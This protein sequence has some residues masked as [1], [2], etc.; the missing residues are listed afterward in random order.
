MDDVRR[1]RP[2]HYRSIFISDVHLGFKGCQ[3]DLL[4]DFLRSTRCQYLFLIGDI[5]DVWNMRNGLYWPQSHNDVIRTIL[6][7]AKH[8]TRVVFIPGNHDEIFREYDGVRFGNLSIH[9]KYIHVTADERRLLLL[10]GDEFDSV[11]QCSPWLAHLGS[12]AYGFLLRMNRS[13]NAVR[14]GFGYRYW[15]L[16]AFLKHKVKNAV[17]YIGNFE[18]AVARSAGKHGVDGLV[19][20]HIHRPEIREIEGVLYCN[21]GDWVE[22]CSALVEHRDGRLQLLDWD[23]VTEKKPSEVPIVGTAA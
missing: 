18:T 12:Y 10:H 1:L 2:N 11:V 6:G 3:A 5:V 8:G 21:D 9:N 4:L 14:K 17:S 7:K 13:V 19:C 22:S 16:A 23:A 15:S 20:G